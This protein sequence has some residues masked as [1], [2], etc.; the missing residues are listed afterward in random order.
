MINYHNI[1]PNN[2]LILYTYQQMTQHNKSD[3]KLCH[4]QLQLCE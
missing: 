1:H 3:I 2:V 4:D